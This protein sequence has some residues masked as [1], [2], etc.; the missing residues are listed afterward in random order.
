[1]R[2]GKIV[3]VDDNEVVLKT[4]R[5]ILSREFRTIQCI[6]APPLLSALLRENDVDVVLLDMNFEIG[7]H[8]GKEGLFWLENILEREKPP[9]VVLITAYGDI[10]LAVSSLKKGATDFIV[11][12][13]NN[14]KLV[15]TII[16]AWKK[17]R[18]STSKESVSEEE[19][20]ITLLLNYFLKKQAT[21]YGKP[22]PS[23]DDE[24]RNKLI[25]ILKQNNIQQ[26][27]QCI[28]RA[29]LFANSDTLTTQDIY[30]ENTPADNKLTSQSSLTL[31]EMEKQFIKE[32][33][34]EKKGNLTLCSQQLNISRQTLY[35]K[36]KK[37]NL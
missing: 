1:M 14:D 35:N 10:G 8:T 37:Y 5:I 23:L 19:E 12:P 7:K 22:L 21:A 6:S 2:D 11:K 27:E 4:L 13:W 9:A 17:H 15:E 31:E 30:P 32:I 20:I 34:Q 24:A 36:I 33:L 16:A 18:K 25:N 28:E 29:I 26:L 3:I